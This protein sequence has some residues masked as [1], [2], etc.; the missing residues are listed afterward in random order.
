MKIVD[1]FRPIGNIKYYK[2]GPSGSYIIFHV[3]LE[4]LE[5]SNRSIIPNVFHGR[6]KVIW[7]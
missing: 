4:S 1:R 7:V 5:K 2:S 6:K 3:S